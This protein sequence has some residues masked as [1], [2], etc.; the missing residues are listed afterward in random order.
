[1]RVAHIVVNGNTYSIN[2]TAPV[3]QG[4]AGPVLDYLRA[5]MDSTARMPDPL[6][7]AVRAAAD[8]YGVKAHLPKMLDEGLKR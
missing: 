2:D 4:A 8:H 7:T 1:M 6:V 3:W 5:T